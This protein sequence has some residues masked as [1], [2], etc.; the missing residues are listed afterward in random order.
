MPFR[1]LF[2]DEA[3]ADLKALK[4]NKG[5]AKRYKAVLK[6]LAYLE[7]NPRHPSLCTHKYT[8]LVGQNGEEIFEAYVENKTPAAYRLFWHYGPQKSHITV[9]SI[10]PHP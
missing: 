7:T 2:T 1:L 4:L 9:V 3:K 8:S 10:T 5:L 6:T